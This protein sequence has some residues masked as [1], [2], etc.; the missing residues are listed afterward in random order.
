MTELRARIRIGHQT[1]KAFFPLIAGLLV[2]LQHCCRHLVLRFFH[3][4]HAAYPI[5]AQTK[6]TG[7][8][9]KQE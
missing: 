3:M 6:Q 7:I 1:V 4:Q 8:S 9:K 2:Y 5:K